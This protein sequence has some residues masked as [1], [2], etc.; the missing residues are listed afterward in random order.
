MNNKELALITIAILV[1]HCIIEWF[2]YAGLTASNGSSDNDTLANNTTNTTN[3]VT[4]VTNA[5]NEESVQQSSDQSYQQ[6]SQSSGSDQYSS[7]K[8]SSSQGTYEENG[9]TIGEKQGERTVVGTSYN[10][11]LGD[12]EAVRDDGSHSLGAP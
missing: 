7:S 9:W 4:N 1:E 12:Y 8:S 6:S 10:E 2:V 11:E 3:N 5:S